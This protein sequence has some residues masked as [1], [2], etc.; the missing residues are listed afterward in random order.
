MRD[1]IR[2]RRSFTKR[3]R[4]DLRD[5]LGDDAPEVLHFWVDGGVSDGIILRAR[6]AKGA[7]ERVA[8]GSWP[9]WHWETA[10]Q[11]LL[12]DSLTGWGANS[13]RGE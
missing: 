13:G 1:R 12:A 2:P 6:L 3:L 11:Q 8:I 10:Y 9:L 4:A 5:A 7:T